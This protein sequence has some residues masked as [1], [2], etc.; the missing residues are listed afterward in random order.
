M[1]H[2]RQA[3]EEIL[4]PHMGALS[5]VFPRAWDS[6]EQF[7]AAAPELR[8]QV[9]TRTRATMLNNFA[10]HAAEDVFAGTPGVVLT[11]QPKF[12]LIVFDSELH[13][14]LKKY[15]GR[16]CQTSGIPTKQRKLFETQQP[17]TNF[18]D[19]TNCVHGY[20]LKPDA[21]GFAETAITCKTGTHLHWKIDIPLGGE[22]GVLLDRPETPSG[23]LP[24][25]G[26]SSTIEDQDQAEEGGIGG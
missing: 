2:S 21:S 1:P 16:S 7:G 18:P 13:V 15:R 4:D 3:A 22:G 14:R 8:L 25:P 5:E 17:L 6:W 23:P 24:E 26:I 11:D 9:C 20:V 10:A 12:L 19:A